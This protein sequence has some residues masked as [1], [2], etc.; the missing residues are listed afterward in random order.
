M[1]TN[2]RPWTE[3][4]REK[5]TSHLAEHGKDW[6]KLIAAFPDRTSNSIKWHLYKNDYAKLS[7]EMKELSRR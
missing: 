2:I 7:V 5:F 6:D 3:I 1:I 4:E